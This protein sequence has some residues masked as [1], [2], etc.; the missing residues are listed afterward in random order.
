MRGKRPGKGRKGKKE[1]EGEGGVSKKSFTVD[2]H[3]TIFDTRHGFKVQINGKPSLPSSGGVWGAVSP[4]IR[5][6]VVG[7]LSG[8][9]EYISRVGGRPKKL[10]Y[11]EYLKP[12]RIVKDGGFLCVY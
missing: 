10:E 6:I 8:E 2:G 9:C 11:T 5:S 7:L 3:S 12:R 4:R 1:R